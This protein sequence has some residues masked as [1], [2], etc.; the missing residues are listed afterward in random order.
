MNNPLVSPWPST[1]AALNWSSLLL[2]LTFGILMIPH[3][4]AKLVHFSEWQKEFMS[5]LG[6]GGAVSIS[7]AIFAELFCSVLLALGLFTRLALIPLI[8]TA[9]V[10]VLV[11]HEADIFGDAAPGFFYLTAYIVLLLLG[12]GRYS[13]DNLLFSRSSSSKLGR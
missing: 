8:I 4:Y 6:M 12:P 1:G 5:F 2:R 7:L 11:A 13:L 10:I 9:L 3:G